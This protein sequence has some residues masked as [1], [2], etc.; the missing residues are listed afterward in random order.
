MIFVSI[1]VQSQHLVENIMIVRM[2]GFTNAR[3]AGQNCLALIQNLILELVG[4]VFGNLLMMK[5][6]A[7]KTMVV[8]EWCEQKRIGKLKVAFLKEMYGEDGLRQMR[9]VK[10]LFDPKGLLNQG[11]LFEE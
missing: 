8:L 6:L 9:A 11:N 1:T 3:V 7:M 5:T 4:L 10:D 2:R